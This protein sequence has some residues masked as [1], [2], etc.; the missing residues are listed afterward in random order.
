VRHAVEDLAL[1]RRLPDMT[2]FGFISD[3]ERA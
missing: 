2:I 1:M 3:Y